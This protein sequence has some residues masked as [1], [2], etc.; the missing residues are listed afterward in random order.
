MSD[1]TARFEHSTLT[2]VLTKIYCRATHA[3]VKHETTYQK[4]SCKYYTLTEES[5]QR[6]GCVGEMENNQMGASQGE[7]L[8]RGNAIIYLISKR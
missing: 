3:A 7:A 4:V 5:D 2:Q 6:T 8:K 1:L